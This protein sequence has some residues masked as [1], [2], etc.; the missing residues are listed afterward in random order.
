MEEPEEQEERDE[1]I[2]EQPNNDDSKEI[3]RKKKYSIKEIQTI[4]KA[5]YKINSIRKTAKLFDVPISTLSGWVKKKN[6]YLAMKHNAV[7]YRFSGGGRKMD[8]SK[9]YD[10]ILLYFIKEG[11]AYDIAITSS[12]VICKAME[13]IPGFKDKKYDNLHHWFKRFRERYSYSIGKLTKTVQTLPKNFLE[14][15]RSHLHTAVKDLMELNNDTNSCILANVSEIPIVLEPYTETILKTV[16]DSRVKIR[17]FGNSKQR[18]SCI[19]CIFA[20]GYRAPPMLVFKGLPENTLDKR[21]NKIKVI[22]EKKIFV[23]CQEN[24]WVDPNTFIKWLNLIWFKIHKPKNIKKQ[25]LYFD[26]GTSHISSDIKKMFT[27]NNCLY[28]LIPPGLATYCQPLDLCIKPFIDGI[29]SKY[30]SFCT[31][32][33]NIKRPTPEELIQWVSSIWWSNIVSNDEIKNAFKKGGI[34]LNLDGSED[35]LF[36]WPKMPDMVLVEDLPSLKKK[37]EFHTMNIDFNE[38]S[39]KEEIEQKEIVFD[40]KRYSISSIRKDIINDSD[41]KSPE[42]TDLTDT[43]DIDAE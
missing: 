42:L 23:V 8:Y 1:E 21:L 18:I 22:L 14:K 15:L 24:S 4:I 29:T 13:L 33:K 43:I 3:K 9:T 41:E 26:A 17:T 19:L 39:E 38:P 10:D 35:Y 6:L 34:N 7:N 31:Y 20:N 40:N 28:R 36:K 11:R 27:D 16:G 12:E 25:I 5:Y 32:W 2:L 30:R 37:K